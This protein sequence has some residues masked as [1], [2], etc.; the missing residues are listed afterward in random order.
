STITLTAT[1]NGDGGGRAAVLSV[2]QSF[3]VTVNNPNRPPHLA[4]IGD[5]V[6]VVG[7]PLQFTI[8]ATDLDGDPLT[9]TPLGLPATATLTPSS[10]YGDALFS[11]TR[12]AGDLGRSTVVFQVADDGNGNPTLIRSDQRSII[13]VVRQDDQAPVLV[14]IADPTVAQQQTLTLHVQA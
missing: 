5:K 3:I 12:P 10:T 2:S 14:P 9:F 1:D 7:Q 11:C 6:A 8:H 4:P 13:L